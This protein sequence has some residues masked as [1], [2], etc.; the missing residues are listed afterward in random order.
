MKFIK[1]DKQSGLPND[2]KSNNPDQIRL[3]DNQDPKAPH[4]VTLVRDITIITTNT[5]E[6]R[7]YRFHGTHSVTYF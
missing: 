3:N 1:P 6:V 5:E 2:R 7:Y 4:Q